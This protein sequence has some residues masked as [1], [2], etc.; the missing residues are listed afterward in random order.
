MEETETAAAEAPS[1]ALKV[2]ASP[3]LDDLFGLRELG[4]QALCWQLSSAKP[5]NGVEQ[6]RDE[7]TTTYWQSDGP[8]QPHWIQVSF[9]R[10][11]ALSHVCLDLDY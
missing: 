5:G 6:I 10:R 1:N 2:S 4:M 7:N 8:A 3:N 11:V 9:Q